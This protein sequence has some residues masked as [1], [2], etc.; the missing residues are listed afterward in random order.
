MVRFFRRRRLRSTRRQGR[1]RPPGEPVPSVPPI[2]QADGPPLRYGGLRANPAA[3]SL[4]RPPKKPKRSGDISLASLHLLPLARAENGAC[5]CGVSAMTLQY[6]HSGL[7]PESSLFNLD[8]RF[9]GNDVWIPASAGMT[10]KKGMTVKKRHA[11]VI[12]AVPLV[13]PVVPPIIPAVPLVIPA[14]AGIQATGRTGWIPAP[15]GAGGQPCRRVDFCLR[16]REGRGGNGV[17][18]PSRERSRFPILSIRP[19]TRRAVARFERAPLATTA[20]LC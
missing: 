16:R 13:I 4:K 15:Q 7:D 9:R 8:S 17:K 5:Y 18:N 2:G 1:P 3:A 6:C 10:G 19:A 20:R 14:E 11:L 12:P